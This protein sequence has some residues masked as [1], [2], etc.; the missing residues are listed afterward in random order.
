MKLSKENILLAT[1]NG[2]DFFK[3]VIKDLAVQG[4]KSRNVKNPFYSDTKASLS[5]FFKHGQWLYKDFGNDDFTGDVFT[6]AA[7]HYNLS[8][9][10]DFIQILKNINRD[11]HL[12]LSEFENMK[13]QTPVQKQLFYIQ[14][15][16]KNKAIEY[17]KSRKLTKH[18]YFF[19]SDAYKHFPDAVVFINN[20]VTGFER[21]FIATPEELVKLN[22]PKTKYEGS[23]SNTL[24][25]AGYDKTQ[26]TIFI[27]EGPNNALSFVEIGHSAIATFGATNIPEAAFLRTFIENKN[28]NLA[29]DGDEAGENFN[30]AIAKL[31]VENKI[32]V[33]SINLVQFP[34][35]KDANNLLIENCL[36][37][38]NDFIGNIDL[39]KFNEEFINSETIKEKPVNTENETEATEEEQP[40][41]DI[42]FKTPTLPESIY[43]NLPQILKESCDLFGEKIEKDVFLIGSIGVIS[44]C[45]PNIKGIYF[46]KPY[47]P[48]LFVF[49]TAPAGS[50][51]GNMEWSKYFGQKIHDTI[52]EQSKKEKANYQLELD[53]YNSRPK[54]EKQE[55]PKPEPPA[56]Q[57]FFIPANSS[58]SAF[59][60]TLSDNNF[61]GIIFE[62]EADTLAN[63]FKQEWG[64]FSDIL[65]KA[66][67]HE[68]TT[69]NRRK[70]NEYIEIKNPHI[71]I[72]LSGTPRQVQNLIPDIENGLFSRFLFYAFED[73]S[74]FKNPFIAYSSVNYTDFFNQK[75]NEIFELYT[76]LKNHPTP[77]FFEFTTEQQDTF[78]SRFKSMLTKS[79][80][81]LG[82]D[83]DANIKRLGVIT[84]RIAM[85]FS[86]LRVREHGDISS[87]MIC[88]D[89]DF[90]TALEISLTLEKHAIAVFHNFPQNNLRD[91]KLKF[92]EQ[93]PNEF[94]RKTFLKTAHD[95]E[96]QDKA[97]EKYITQFRKKGFLKHGYNIYTKNENRK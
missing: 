7:L 14:K 68:T 54:K 55:I 85:L 3:F 13:E 22:L 52:V 9:K 92:F 96:I 15:T 8:V 35:N 36:S 72:V 90:Q 65:R 70:D 75:S 47:S 5:I 42:I 50:G 71:T 69:M 20:S 24:Y 45:L 51:K 79:K 40:D 81:L 63:T 48:H 4:N 67:H 28:V 26:D 29:G 10:Q 91:K 57:M 84:F 23:K 95:L 78:T 64:N 82:R 62:T 39:V 76:A 61:K 66:F 33:K 43:N 88:S 2:L 94:D 41:E 1:D 6:F 46:S 44:A 32:P 37:N 17:Q 97:A 59:L 80:L 25:V 89:I 21:R 19:Q 49:I 53:Q 77:I 83:F 87:P 31:I 27:C 93:L 11:L 30:T 34:D 58:S 12:N 38:L 16:S 56:N 60:Q 86:A 73:D 18:Q 74:E